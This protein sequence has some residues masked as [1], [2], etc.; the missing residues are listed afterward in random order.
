MQKMG[1]DAYIGFKL[2]A[3]T[4]KAIIDRLIEASKAGVQID[5]IIRGSVACNPALPVKPTIFV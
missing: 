3:L 4:D 1:K 5:M 2:N